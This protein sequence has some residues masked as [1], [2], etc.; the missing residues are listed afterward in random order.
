MTSINP[1]LQIY[2]HV[3]LSMQ[4]A[5]PSSSCLQNLAPR[6]FCV[7]NQCK[8]QG[9]IYLVHPQQQLFLTHLNSELQNRYWPTSQIDFHQNTGTE[10]QIKDFYVFKINLLC[11]YGT[12]MWFS[13]EK[14]NV[15]SYSKRL[16]STKTTF[17]YIAPQ[18]NFLASIHLLKP[19]WRWTTKRK[20]TLI[21]Q[22]SLFS[23]CKF[24]SSATQQSEACSEA[25]REAVKPLAL[26]WVGNSAVLN[27]AWSFS[28]WTTTR[29][30][31]IACSVW[32]TIGDLP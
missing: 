23:R 24:V 20:H 32:P 31:G 4:K 21:H 3:S 25:C 27:E 1:I 13:N 22:D 29:R 5:A 14:A 9:S 19:W 18:N 7:T 12:Q 10:T 28:Q 2:K 17:S 11:L 6:L 16:L 8:Y 15:H 30:T 26:L